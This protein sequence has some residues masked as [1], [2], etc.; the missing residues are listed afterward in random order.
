MQCPKTKI[1]SASRCCLEDT[2]T[3]S[4]MNLNL[5]IKMMFVMDFER[6]LMEKSENC[7]V[8]CYPQ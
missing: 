7:V 1:A 2:T 8:E 3:Y 6:K 5:R 4:S